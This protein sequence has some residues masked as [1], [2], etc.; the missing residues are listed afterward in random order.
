MLKLTMCLNWPIR[1]LDLL[2]GPV[3]SLLMIWI[4]YNFFFFFVNSFSKF[5]LTATFF[6]KMECENSR[7]SCGYWA[8]V[9]VTALDGNVSHEDVGYGETTNQPTDAMAFEMASKTAISDAYKRACRL[10]GPALGNS[11]YN[12]LYVEEVRRGLHRDRPPITAVDRDPL[13]DDVKDEAAC[14]VTAIASEQPTPGSLSALVG[15]LRT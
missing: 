6:A 8:T 7:F 14:D 2:V 4:L 15:P 13:L 11:L 5:L 10:F 1:Y 3:K 9:R 12:K